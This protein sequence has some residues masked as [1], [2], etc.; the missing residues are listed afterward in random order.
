MNLSDGKA[1]PYGIAL[2]FVFIIGLIVATIMTAAKVPVEESD[3]FMRNY[4][5]ADREA[6]AI[7]TR[8]IAFNKQYDVQFETRA[9]SAKE[10]VLEY[11]VSD[12]AGNPVTNAQITAVITRPNKHEYDQ[13]LENPAVSNDGLY[14]FGSVTL[15]Q[16]GRWDIMAHIK[17]GEDERYFNLKADTR[18]PQTTEY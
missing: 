15:A 9:I 5:Q 17:V 4:H 18:Y 12:K 1:W 6:N 2:S 10:T 13:T 11:R 16:E 3:L 7:L 8:Q 14:R